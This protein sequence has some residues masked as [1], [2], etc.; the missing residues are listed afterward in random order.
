MTLEG[1]ENEV[2]SVA[3]SSSGHLLATCSRDKSVWIWE[4]TDEEEFECAAV[5]NAHTQD[6][7]R[8]AWHPTQNIL[9]S[10][11]YDNTIKLFEEDQSDHDWVCTA[12]L[13]GHDST[14]WG[15]S[16]DK[17]GTRLA[18]AS[19]DRTVKIWQS[20]PPG[21]EEGIGT[22]DGETAW[23]CVCTLSGYHTRSVFD[24]S[25][26]HLS[27]ENIISSIY[28]ISILKEPIYVI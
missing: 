3:W 10:A 18:S 15:I 20:Y 11:S 24:V 1:H 27:G 22:V 21:N 16:F 23:R 7:K 19:D 4:M 6:V 2:K 5:L 8:V 13:T 17:T 14:V 25:W 9:A 26:C 28:S 12:T